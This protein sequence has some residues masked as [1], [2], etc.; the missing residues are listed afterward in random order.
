MPRTR[1]LIA[2]TL[3][4]VAVAVIVSSAQQPTTP[5]PPPAATA[6]Q[7]G[8][9]AQ[10]P[11]ATT[12]LMSR[13][14]TSVTYDAN[15]DTKID[16]VGTP[17]MPRARG[18]AE[19]KTESSGPVNVE[20][21]VKGLTPA[22]Q[23]GAEYLT[24][25][26]WA[27]PPQ[28]RPKNLGELRLDDGE[29]EI[30][31]TVDV[32]TF[33][34]VVTAEPYYA[35]TSPSEVVVLE[36]VL[37]EDTK[38]HTSIATLQYD[39]VPRGA[40]VAAA[41]PAGYT[42]P[43]P[44]KKE[45]PDVQ[46]AR[47]AIKIAQLAQ[48]DKYAASDLAGAQQLMS[49][50]EGLLPKGSKRDIISSA[51]ATI[52]QAEATRLQS[53]TGKA[54]AEQAAAR[55]TAAAAEQAARDKAAQE[56]TARAQ[57]DQARVQAE[58]DRQRAEALARQAADDRQKAEAAKAAAEAQAR[59]AEQDKVALRATLQKQFS[60]VLETHDT[61]RGLIVNVGDVLFETGRYAL[62]P[63]ARE[64]LARFSG[65][66]L[67]HPGLTVQAEGFTDSTGS[68]ETN[69]KLSEQRADAVAQYLMSQGIA[70]DRLKTKGYG[71]SY[72]VATNGTTEGRSQNRRV[73]LVVSGD[74]IGTP[75]GATGR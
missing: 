13:R 71:P 17:M 60:E 9:P 75:I 14:T 61:P 8:A 11:G 49:K 59:K 56:A 54:Q 37:R 36:N 47:N 73:E 62:K 74:I 18:E 20:A 23:F 31:T 35:V 32:Q 25:V 10:A 7:P 30:K 6:Q 46:Q 38:G 19:I 22:G 16:L 3:V 48:A 4:P 67:G 72:P 43:A 53:V 29:S 21:K 33:S 28:G 2:L 34:L 51:R 5:V 41:G 68:A 12:G 50:T 52:Q 1:H 55:A 15:R 66:I 45:P 39:I 64:K 26:L 69:Q 58:Q 40:Y 27:I 70:G 44:G 42:L 63:E 57:A 24:Y 65:I